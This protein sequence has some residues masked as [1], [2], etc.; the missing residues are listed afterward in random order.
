MLSFIYIGCSYMTLYFDT[1]KK[2]NTPGPPPIPIFGNLRQISA[3]V[4]LKEEFQYLWYNI[5]K[6]IWTMVPFKVKSCRIIFTCAGRN[7]A[8]MIASMQLYLNFKAQFFFRINLI[9]SEL[10]VKRWL[11]NEICFVMY[12]FMYVFIHALFNLIKYNP[13]LL[14]IIYIFLRD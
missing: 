11:K 2:R 12:K 7:F 6:V 5:L 10:E 9:Y 4:G 1:F 14:M 8:L 13:L 3:L